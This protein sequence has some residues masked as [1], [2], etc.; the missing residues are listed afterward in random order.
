MLKL[1]T[2]IIVFVAVIMVCFAGCSGS[3][4]QNA[5]LGGGKWMLYEIGGTQYKAPAGGENV[6]I[7]FN[8]GTSQA[9]GM[10]SCNTFSGSYAATG[11]NIKM[12]PMISTKMA[13]D[14]MST[15]MKFMQSLNKA[16]SYKIT[17][18]KLY[19]MDESS[20]VLCRLRTE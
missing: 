18:G 17:G 8:T 4:T 6:Y 11:S 19:L 7:V 12:G 3:V 9:S 10:A 14:D 16:A 1:Q 13:C 20:A 15:E 5:E 2:L